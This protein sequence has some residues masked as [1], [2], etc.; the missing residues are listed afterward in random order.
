MQPQRWATFSLC[1][2]ILGEL[3]INQWKLGLTYPQLS[4]LSRRGLWELMWKKYWQE[5]PRS[6]SAGSLCALPSDETDHWISRVARKTP[7]GDQESLLCTR[8]LAFVMKEAPLVF[9]L[10]I[11]QWLTSHPHASS[12]SPSLMLKDG[13]RYSFISVK[14]K[15]VGIICW[16][17]QRLVGQKSSLTLYFHKVHPYLRHYS[18][19]IMGASHPTNLQTGQSSLHFD[20]FPCDDDS[21]PIQTV[22]LTTVIQEMPDVCN[23]ME[24]SVTERERL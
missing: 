21:F 23:L 22:A 6:L 4:A 9:P 7:I 5:V 18:S 8:E 13:L 11:T 24:D 15:A 3:I 12:E 2:R 19:I 16:K 1:S 17:T 10:E 20:I 14:Y